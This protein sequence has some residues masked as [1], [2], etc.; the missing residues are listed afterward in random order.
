MSRHM[1]DEDL[2]E[3]ALRIRRSLNL[4]GQT[5]IDLMT[6][7]QRLKTL[8]P[9][10]GYIRVDNNAMP[11]AEG[12]WDAEQQ[13]LKLRE[14]TF[15]GMQAQ[16]VRDRMT[17]AHELSHCFLAHNGI[18][19]RSFAKSAAEQFALET[20][21]EEREASRLAPRLI[22]PAYLIDPDDSVDE[23]RRRFGL[24]L[25]AAAIRREEVNRLQRRASGQLRPLPPNVVDF[26]KEAKRRGQTVTADIGE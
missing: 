2:E 14:S 13:L 6:V 17:V 12:Q 26:L 23:I 5:H 25:E 21:R 24:S 8:R 18:R 16:R 10:F 9:G 15:Q 1:T 7:I 4:E 11:D 19:N 3:L 20:V 22:A